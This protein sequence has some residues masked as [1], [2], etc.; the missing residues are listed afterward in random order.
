MKTRKL[1]RKRNQNGNI[2][3]NFF[4]I[5]DGEEPFYVQ[6]Y[7]AK[8]KLSVAMMKQATLTMNVQNARE[9]KTKGKSGYVVPSVLSVVP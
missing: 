8:M 9:L 2:Y 3:I 7:G 4:R 5:A 6:W 1:E